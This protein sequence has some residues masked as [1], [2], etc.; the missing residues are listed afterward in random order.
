MTNRV[1]TPDSVE[2]VIYLMSAS[3]HGGTW[4]DACCTSS[5]VTA[6]TGPN[7]IRASATRARPTRLAA[8]VASPACGRCRPAPSPSQRAF[9]LAPSRSSK[10][11]FSLL[12]LLSRA[13]T[14]HVPPLTVS[15][16]PPVCGSR[17]VPLAPWREASPPATDPPVC[18]GKVRCG[19]GDSNS[20]P[21]ERG[22]G[23]Q[24]SASANS[25]T[26]AFHQCR[27]RDSNSHERKAHY[28][29][30]VARLPIPPPRHLDAM[31][32]GI[33]GR[34]RTS[35]LLDRNQTL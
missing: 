2:S 22:L 6:A 4:L 28:A 8:V 1:H 12:R 33:P 31:H 21:R 24:P 29:L 23:P 7:R 16:G 18:L 13:L 32:P 9:T 3:R 14:R 17:E 34:T 26:P 10:Q 20:H 5:P 27:G 11:V 19:R 15:R 25:A 30:N 35:D